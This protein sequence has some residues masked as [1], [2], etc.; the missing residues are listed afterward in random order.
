MMR[1]RIPGQLQQ[2]YVALLALALVAAAFT[3]HAIDPAQMPNA[4]LQARYQR[5]I[6]ELRCVKCQNETLADSEVE[7]AAEIR[8]QIRS[9]LLEGK[10]DD[11]IR[12]YMVS[13]YTEFILFKPR[14]SARNAWL[15]LSPLVL[16]LVGVIVAARVIRARSALLPADRDPVDEDP[17]AP[18]AQGARHG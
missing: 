18:A 12:D 8:Q 5:L 4:Q 9:M 16:L 1:N 7:I 3:A 11:Q 14:F 15:W 13:R 2:L 6:H 17:S 10:T